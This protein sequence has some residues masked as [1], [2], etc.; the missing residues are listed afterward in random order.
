MPPAPLAAWRRWSCR[1]EAAKPLVAVTTVGITTQGAMKAGEV[2][3]AA[4]YETI[5]FHAVGTGGPRDGGDD[6]AGPDRR[7]ARLSRPS[8][9]R[10]RCITRCSPAGPTG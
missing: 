3:E 9:C 4:G 7:R 5:V 1:T 10:T 2:L 6:A 8:K